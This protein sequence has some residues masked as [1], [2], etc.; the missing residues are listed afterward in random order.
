METALQGLSRKVTEETNGQLEDPFT[1]EE[2]ATALSQMCPT[3]ALGPDGLPTVYFQKHWQSV[4]E[5]V[6]TTC[7]LILNEQGNPA[8]INHIYL[9]LVPKISK[10]KK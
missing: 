2:I 4:R 9:A 5:G 10:P 7:L 8:L 6:V 3:K 1:L